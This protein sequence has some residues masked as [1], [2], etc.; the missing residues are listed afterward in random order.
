M[1]WAPQGFGP[2][3]DPATLVPRGAIY[4]IRE[5][6]AEEARHREA[7]QHKAKLEQPGRKEDQAER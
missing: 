5:E 6:E 4:R 2:D 3:P 7:E 1:N